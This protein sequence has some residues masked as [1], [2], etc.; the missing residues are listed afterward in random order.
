MGYTEKCEE[1]FTRYQKLLAL[2][3]QFCKCHDSTC[4]VC[5]DIKELTGDS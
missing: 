1:L 5:L 4:P 2:L 3:R